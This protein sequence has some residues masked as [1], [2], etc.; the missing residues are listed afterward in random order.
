[1]ANLTKV[2]V[3]YLGSGIGHQE[4]AHVC[5]CVCGIEEALGMRVGQ[6]HNY[7]AAF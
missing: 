6:P 4:K 1:M 2:R 3:T 5:V 7:L